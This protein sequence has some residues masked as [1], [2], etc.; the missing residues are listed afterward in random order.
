[1]KLRGTQAGAF[2]QDVRYA[3]RAFFKAPAFTATVLTALAL[4]IGANTAI[5]SVINA[6]LLKPLT[7]PDPGRIV[8][9]FV[10]TPGGPAYGGSAAKFNVWRRQTEILQDVSA[11]EYIGA[12][13]NL[14]GGAYPEQVHAIRVSSDYF[15][16]LGAPVLHGRTFTAEEDRPGG[17]HAGVITHGLWQ[18][19]FGGDPR[20]IG[21]SI[22][23]SGVPYT[24][25]G[26]VG[27]GFNTELDSPPDI[28]LPFQID[29]TSSEHAHYFTVAGRLKPGVTLAM[30]NAQ[31]QLAS[32]EFGRRFPNIL[33]SRDTF[34]VQ[35]LQEGMVSDVRSSLLVLAGAVSFVLLIAC[36]NAA[37]LLLARA[38]GRKREIAVRS[39]IGAGR[40]RIIRQLLTESIVLSLAGG[41]FGL[42]LGFAGVRALLAVNPGSLPRIGEHGSAMAMDWRLLVFT[43]SISL[44]TG[45]LFGLV[46]ALDVSRA[47]LSAL[48][49]RAPGGPPPVFARTRPGPSWSSAR[50][51]SHWC[52]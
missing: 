24:V 37:N 52:C 34:K 44:I 20:I 23:L 26:V 4:G 1:M 31:L 45:V 48:S 15:R 46:P 30:A 39:A 25:V 50:C 43:A 21:K 7:W 42:A 40:G 2:F 33:G 29:P 41:A 13:L 5:F 47:D 18:R 27:S 11:W 3:I 14:T 19:R 28:W 16:L 36:A 22:S 51:P 35:P 10:M 38:T 32:G 9:F 6:V 8:F 17:G 49:R 12:D